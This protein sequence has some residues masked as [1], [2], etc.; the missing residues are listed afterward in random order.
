M[1]EVLDVAALVDLEQRLAGLLAGSGVI[2]PALHRL[3]A[4]VVEVLGELRVSSS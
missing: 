1:V 4:A 3:R 2:P